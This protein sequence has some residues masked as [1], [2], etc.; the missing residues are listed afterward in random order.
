MEDAET[1]K[2]ED[3]RN[4][5]C[6]GISWGDKSARLARGEERTDAVEERDGERDKRES[7]REGKGEGIGLF[8]D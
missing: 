7:R 3:G 1:R 6:R 5:E 4:V 8:R 2:V